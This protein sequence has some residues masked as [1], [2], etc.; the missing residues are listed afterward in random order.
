[1]QRFTN[2]DPHWNPENMVYG[3]KTHKDGEIPVPDVNSVVQSGNLYAY[4]CGNPVYYCDVSG[5][6]AVTTLI[7]IGSIVIGVAAASYT[8]YK[9]YQYNG[10]IDWE[11]IV[12]TGLSWFMLSYSFGMSSYAI[13]VSYCNYHG[14]GV[15]SEVNFDA[16]RSFNHNSIK[17][18][19]VTFPQSSLDKAFQK[20]GTVFGNYADGSNNSVSAFT[21]DLKAFIDGNIQMSGTYRS[22]QGT[23]I[24]NETTRQWVFINSDGS[25]NTGF[26]LSEAQ[27]KYMIE[28]GTVK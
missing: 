12:F 23:H 15:L 1:M 26:K 28:T 25:F 21:N 22:T 19:N 4:C 2:E 10:E 9:S 5:E 13:Y 17:S 27:F 16:S 6:I 7:L 18:N 14:Y 24:F 3:D 8:A 11:N 20:H